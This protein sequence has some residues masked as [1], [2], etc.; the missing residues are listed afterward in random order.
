M[1]W[2]YRSIRCKTHRMTCGATYT[3]GDK[4]GTRA[5][6]YIG[7]GEQAQW[8]GSIGWDGHPDSL[9]GDYYSESNGVLVATTEDEFRAAVTH[10]LINRKDATTPEH[11]WPW[12]WDDSRTTDYAYAFDGDGIY[13]SNFGYAWFK[14]DLSDEEGL[15][16]PEERD[17]DEK[18]AVFPD[19][20]ARKNTR[21]AGPASGLMVVGFSSDGKAK[22]LSEREAQPQPDR[23]HASILATLEQH[24]SRRDKEGVTPYLEVGD[25]DLSDLTTAI[26]ERLKSDLK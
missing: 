13:A 9:M 3:G 1:S 22:V 25:M 12:P 16:Q 6:F 8:L 24:C 18:V 23:V 15:G 10:M 14:I 20:S 7:R 26:V 5:D 2:S 11:G 19:M 17:G 4:M 21:L